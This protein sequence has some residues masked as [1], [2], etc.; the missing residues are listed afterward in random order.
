M[1]TGERLESLEFCE[2]QNTFAVCFCFSG[3]EVK[4][5]G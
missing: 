2:E 3:L 4:T 1:L 5:I